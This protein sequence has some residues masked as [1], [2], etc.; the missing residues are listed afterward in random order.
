MV[1]RLT[2]DQKVACSIDVGFKNPEKLILIFFFFLFTNPTPIVSGFSEH[3][4]IF[5]LSSLKNLS[6]TKGPERKQ[7]LSL[8]ENGGRLLTDISFVAEIIQFHLIVLP[9][10][11]PQMSSLLA[12]TQLRQDNLRRDFFEEETR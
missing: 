3:A 1:A 11:K 4:L 10:H 7:T 5:S 12:E 6:Y 2:P 9:K 8:P